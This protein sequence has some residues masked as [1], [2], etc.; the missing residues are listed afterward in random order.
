MTP[1]YVVTGFLNAGKTTF[2]NRMFESRG[3]DKSSVLILQFELGETLLKVD[4][5]NVLVRAFKKRD[6]ERNPEAI[7]RTV[8]ALVREARIS[9][10]WIEWNGM[11]AF[12]RLAS[13]LALPSL[14]ELMK[15]SKV[16]H[17]AN[18][19]S[20]ETLIG[21]TGVALPTQIANSDFA[22]IR[23]TQTPDDLMRMRRLLSTINPGITV[24]ADNDPNVI[25][26]KIAQRTESP[27]S[28]FIIMVVL[29]VL[30]YFGGSTLFT[31]AQI[32][33][34]IIINVFVGI[35]LQA[36]PFLLIG[37][38]L[39]SL[40]QTYINR[41]TIERRFPKTVGLGMLTAVIGGFLL[42]VCDCASIPIFRTLVR[43]GVPLPAAITFMTVSPV[44]NPVVILSTYYAF[45]GDMTVVGARVGLGLVS[46]LVIGLSFAIRK[47]KT[48]VLSGAAWDRITCS[49]GSFED[50][51]A[52]SGA[53]AKFRLFLRHAQTEFFDVG[54]YLII[55]TFVSSILQTMG[56]GA[57]T[58]AQ[59][60]AGRIASTI[61]MMAMAFALSLCSSSV[62][63]WWDAA[64]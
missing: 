18:A 32:D 31:N 50:P 60:G 63:R 47:P 26:K 53:R 6:M 22:V 59:S 46:A 24:Y 2:L 27:F 64:L 8:A 37:I 48:S 51:N 54:K 34:N 17:V 43:K 56:S 12:E 62:T 5:P 9:A 49:C 1:T 11:E 25:R 20:L 52:V 13:L 21:R 35:I 7:A 19:A 4:T 55:G 14:S 15:L 23:G 16:L 33:I 40:I 45:N 58:L 3:Q 61:L 28:G 41:E 42:P 38:L 36:V 44:I 29:M 30:I 39:S 10:V 57:F